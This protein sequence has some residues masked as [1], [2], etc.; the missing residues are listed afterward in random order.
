MPEFPEVN[1]QVRYLRERCKGWKIAEFGCTSRQHQKGI[2]EDERESMLTRLL[3]GAELQEITQRG[4]QVILKFDTGMITSHLMFR[5]RWSVEGDDFISPYKFHKKKPTEKSRT[6]WITTASGQRLN[7]HTPEYKAKIEAF[8]DVSNAADLAHL[9]KLGPEVIQLPEIDEAFAEPW[10]LEFFST[11]AGK[12]KQAIKAFLLDQKKQSG[13][14]NMY[15][16][17]A[18]YDAGIHPAR[19]ANSLSGNEV[20]TLWQAS[21]DMLR[22]ALEMELDYGRLL[23][24]Y[25]KSEDPDGNP[26]EVIKVSGRDTFWV[27]ARQS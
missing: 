23:R 11:K 4:K 16:C 26:V 8:P 10:S 18:L 20:E 24:I 1:V 7:F 2:P 13:L 5:G 19:P 6:F 12:S 3:V 22:K 9:K 15:V 25:R 21:R 17:E 14:G 27:P